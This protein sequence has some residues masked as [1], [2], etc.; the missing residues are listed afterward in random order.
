MR[1]KGRRQLLVVVLGLIGLGSGGAAVFITQLAAGPVALLAVGLV[2]LLVGL[3]G[4][5]P[6]RLKFGDNE[7]AWDAVE[8]FVERAA[9]NASPAD[10]PGLALLLGDLAQAAP[11]VAAPALSAF[12]YEDMILGMLKEAALDL[13]RSQDAA[14]SLHLQGLPEQNEPAWLDTWRAI[15]PDAVIADYRGAHV[16]VEIKAGRIGGDVVNRLAAVLGA[17]QLIPGDWAPGVLLVSRD[18]PSREARH[19]IAERL[20]QAVTVE[21]ASSEDTPK[22]ITA[23]GEAFSRARKQ[24]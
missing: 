8:T 7:A 9:E 16:V 12:A 20:P 19:A 14:V 6:S 18:G 1:I 24:S 3:G 4:R 11:A 22:L 21:I 13:A 10:R 15:R 2:L 17:Y 23:V 5:L